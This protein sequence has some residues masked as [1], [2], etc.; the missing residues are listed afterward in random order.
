MA[1]TEAQL[2]ALRNGQRART[3]QMRAA[4]D[5]HR[6]AVRKHY[7]HDGLSMRATA[8]KIGVRVQ[9]LARAMDRWGWERRAAGGR[10]GARLQITDASAKRR[11]KINAIRRDEAASYWESKRAAITDMLWRG[12][13][14]REIAR[15]LG[16]DAA[17]VRTWLPKLGIHQ[18][19]YDERDGAVSL[20]RRQLKAPRAVVGRELGEEIA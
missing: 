3:E 15:E 6:F 9:S 8:E 18:V 7:Y 16:K 13:S 12:M 19:W 2:A 4:I 17:S 11:F 1:R 10:K 5:K 14:S 20:S